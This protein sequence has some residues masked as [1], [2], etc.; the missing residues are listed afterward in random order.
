MDLR[1]ECR[2]GSETRETTLAEQIQRDM[3]ETCVAVFLR[4]QK[5]LIFVTVMTYIGQK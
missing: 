3:F 2:I 1:R 4:P 5:K